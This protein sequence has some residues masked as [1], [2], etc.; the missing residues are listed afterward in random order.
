MTIENRIKSPWA[1]MI[2]KNIIIILI[3]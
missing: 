2:S 3:Y 1:T